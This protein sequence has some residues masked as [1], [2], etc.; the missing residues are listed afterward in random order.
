MFPSERS[1]SPEISSITWATARIAIGGGELADHAEVVRAEEVGRRH[2]EVDEQYDEHE[3]DARLLAPRDE[4]HRPEGDGSRPGGRDLERRPRQQVAV[5]L[6]A[7]DRVGHGSTMSPMRASERQR[8]SG[9]QLRGLRG[10]AGER[11]QLASTIFCAS[12]SPSNRLDVS[13]NSFAVSELRNTSPVFVSGGR[14]TPPDSF[15]R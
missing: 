10:V 3:G 1:I 15:D 6:L 2:A 4:I 13:R 12:S 5:L 11:H 14:T 7:P 8:A 9:Q